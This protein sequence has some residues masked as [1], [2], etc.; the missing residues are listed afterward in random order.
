VQPAANL[1]GNVLVVTGDDGGVPRADTNT[2]TSGDGGDLVLA[3]D[4]TDLV[5]G[6]AGIDILKGEAGNDDLNGGAGIDILDGGLGDDR[7]DGGP[8]LTLTDEYR[9]FADIDFVVTETQVIGQG[10][11][12]LLNIGFVK[13]TLS[14]QEPPPDGMAALHVAPVRSRTR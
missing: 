10:T 2:I 12:T 9:V 8:G 6:G 4:G 13:L 11:D 14:G 3:G 7:L 1:D 5:G